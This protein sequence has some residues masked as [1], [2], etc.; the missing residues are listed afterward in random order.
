V[1]VLVGVASFEESGNQGLS[2]VV[3]LTEGKR[4]EAEV[5]E[6]ER[7]YREIQMGLA[8]ANRVAT[9]G[10]LTGSIAH[11]MNQPIA[12]TLANAE[13]TLRWL[14]AQ[15]PNL[16]EVRQALD[17]IVKNTHRRRRGHPPAAH[18]EDPATEGPCRHK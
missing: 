9:M 13:A 4:A 2:F 11:E 3:D 7:R 14:G 17:C 8:H 18:S 16:E 10:Q 6:S 5:H 12:A 1:P 15:S